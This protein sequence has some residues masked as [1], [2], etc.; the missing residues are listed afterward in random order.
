MPPEPVPQEQ[1][2]VF[3]SL[4][5]VVVRQEPGL[6][7]AALGRAA[8]AVESDADLGALPGLRS[9]LRHELANVLAAAEYVSGQLGG[10]LVALKNGDAGDRDE[11]AEIIEHLTLARD[12]IRRPPNPRPSTLEEDLRDHP[13]LRGLVPPG[14]SYARISDPS[15]NNPYP[16]EPPQEQGVDPVRAV[17]LAAAMWDARAPGTP[18][19]THD[20]LIALASAA[21]RDAD[22]DD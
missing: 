8:A 1:G 12:E 10:V 2:D 20:Q 6:L 7:L 19:L 18:T 4:S 3:A 21:L 5:D 17:R 15:S 16:P 9:H 14:E 13:P 11:L 22:L